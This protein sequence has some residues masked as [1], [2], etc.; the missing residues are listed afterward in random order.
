MSIIN[1]A[2]ET[3]SIL[4]GNFVQYGRC[5]HTSLLVLTVYAFAISFL[6]SRDKVYNTL[7]YVLRR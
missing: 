6:L 1:H 7:Q 3:Y 4:F 2:G 5:V